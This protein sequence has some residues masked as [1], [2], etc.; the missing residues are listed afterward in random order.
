MCCNL[1][2]ENLLCLLTILPFRTHGYI[3]LKN[4]S[5]GLSVCL[6]GSLSPGPSTNINMASQFL[7]VQD[8]VVIFRLYTF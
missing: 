2:L 6:L 5:F 7:S 8:T 4:T 3:D 1:G